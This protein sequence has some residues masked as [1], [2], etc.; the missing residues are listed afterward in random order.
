M[1]KRDDDPEADPH[2]NPVPA[3]APDRL[4]QRVLAV[5]E[6]VGKFIEGWGFKSI[7]GKVWTLLAVSATPIA[8][9]DIAEILGVSRSL[10]SLAIAELT[11]YGLVRAEGEHR[12]APYSARLDVW[13]AIADVLR[14]RE[15]MLIE[16][17]R[18]ALEAAVEEAELAREGG[19]RGPYDLGRMRLLLAMT[20]L[21][22]TVLRV[23][24]S[25][26][27][28]RSLESFERWLRDAHRFMRRFRAP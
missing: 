1:A 7:Q 13:P 15:W 12:N 17:A 24:L 16:G 25:V 3:A 11:T 26:R 20:E 14:G 6:A 4:T 23:L 5:T 18:V 27:V 10:V 8:Q 21:A 22:Q 2:P 19:Y 28:P 9:T